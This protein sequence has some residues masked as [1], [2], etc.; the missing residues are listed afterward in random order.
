MD[1]RTRVRRFIAFDLGRVMTGGAELPLREGDEVILLSQ[2]DVLWLASP[3]VQRALRG[4]AAAPLPVSA[5]AV[6]A[7]AAGQPAGP[8][9]GAAPLR[10]TARR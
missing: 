10:W 8:V 1:E 6:A 2:A 3:A 4:E 9:P 7:G 5:A